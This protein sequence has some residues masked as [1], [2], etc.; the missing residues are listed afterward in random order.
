MT[1]AEQAKEAL[2]SQDTFAIIA[3]SADFARAVLTAEELAD[4]LEDGLC[5]SGIPGFDSSR[6]DRA[7]KA[8]R[9]TTGGQP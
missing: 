5:N 1:L 9:A 6:L 3:R 8:H 4:A 2:E 7:L